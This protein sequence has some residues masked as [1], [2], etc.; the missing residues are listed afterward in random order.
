MSVCLE[1]DSLG[2]TVNDA[3]RSGELRHWSTEAVHLVLASP[4]K[5]AAAASRS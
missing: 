2:K 5:T 1:I 3:T 4:S